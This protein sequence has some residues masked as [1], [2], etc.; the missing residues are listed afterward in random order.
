MYSI[1]ITFGVLLIVA[2]FRWMLSG[3]K[4]NSYIELFK[5]FISK[6]VEFCSRCKKNASEKEADQIIQ[7]SKQAKCWQYPSLTWI[8]FTHDS[9]NAFT[10]ED[11]KI[12]FSL[13]S[14]FLWV[15]GQ[16][17]PC[18]Y[19]SQSLERTHKW[20]LDTTLFYYSGSFSSEIQEWAESVTSGANLVGRLLVVFMV[21][22]NLA[23]MCIYIIDVQSGNMR[24]FTFY[25]V[26]L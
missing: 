18:W 22:C 25:C 12:I 19:L 15:T 21:F 11:R 26:C 9:L 13:S 6:N 4:E 17:V 20:E 3:K 8:I 5:I 7:T 14:I 23:A 2:I 16:F 1:L 24:P 10:A